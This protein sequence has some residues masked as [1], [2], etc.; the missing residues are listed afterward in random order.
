MSTSGIIKE[1]ANKGFLVFENEP[2]KPSEELL[3][4]AASQGLDVLTVKAV[5]IGDICLYDVVI[6]NPNRFSL[7]YLQFRNYWSGEMA[8]LGYIR[9]ARE[10]LEPDH[11]IYFLQEKGGLT[12]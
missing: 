11:K 2:T 6:F 9:V 4:Q 5:I 12:K 3:K 8:E 7:S 1:A 10:V